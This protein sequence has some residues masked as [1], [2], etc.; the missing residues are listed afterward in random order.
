MR[1]NPSIHKSHD[2][3][4]RTSAA[5]GSATPVANRNYPQNDSNR[6][7]D[8]QYLIEEIPD[9]T[10]PVA[11]DYLKSQNNYWMFDVIHYVTPKG[12]HYFKVVGSRQTGAIVKID[13]N[14]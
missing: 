3:L 8:P 4:H 2:P 14:P 7:G 11:A 13:N 1:F 5:E 6:Q 9:D 10:D 12:E